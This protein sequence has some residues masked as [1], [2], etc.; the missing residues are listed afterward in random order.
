MKLY[1][2]PEILKVLPDTPLTTLCEGDEKQ[3]ITFEATVASNTPI[4]KWSWFIEGSDRNEQIVDVAGRITGSNTGVLTIKPVLRSDD[5]L[6][7]VKVENKCGPT[8]SAKSELDVELKAH[9]TTSLPALT[10]ACPGDQVVLTMEAEG[11][12]VDYT[13]EKNAGT[14]EKLQTKTLVN[15]SNADEGVYTCRVHNACG[16]DAASTTLVVTDTT[17]FQLSAGGAYCEGED[18][19][20]FTLNGS[21]DGILYKLY[22][23]Q[24]KGGDKLEQTLT[25]TGSALTFKKC[26]TPLKQ[27]ASFY[28]LAEQVDNGI[29]CIYRMD[30]EAVL[31]Q[32]PLPNKYNLTIS[33]EYCSGETFAV[34][35]LSGSEKDS[36]EYTLEQKTTTG[37]WAGIGFAQVGTGAAMT[38]TVE[39][40]GVYRVSARNKNTRCRVA[41]NYEREILV[42]PLPAPVDLVAENGNLI[43]CAGVTSDVVLSVPDPEAGC[44]YTLKKE[45]EAG[46]SI[47]SAP[48]TWQQV[49]AGEYVLIAKNQWGCE[50]QVAQQTVIE[51]P[52]PLKFTLTGGGYYCN[53]E[54]ADKVLTLSGSERGK[55]YELYSGGKLIASQPGAGDILIYKV[56]LS[57]KT[58]TVK[59]T[60]TLTGCSADMEGSAVIKANDLRI[61]FAESPIKFVYGN[62][63]QIQ[64]T[65][66]G[67]VGAREITWEPLSK[68]KDA[69]QEHVEDPVT[70]QLFAGQRFGVTVTDEGSGCTATGF[71]NAM[72]DGDVLTV[73]INAG[74]CM[75]PV[76]TIF[77]CQDEKARLCANAMGGSGDYEYNWY[78]VEGSKISSEQEFAYHIDRSGYVYLEVT[79]RGANAGVQTG[80][81]KVWVQLCEPPTETTLANSGLN[82]SYEGEQ[83]QVVVAGTQKGTTYILEHS[84]NNVNF[85]EANCPRMEGTGGQV[86]FSM[87]YEGEESGGFYRVKA[88]NTY[89][90]DGLVTTCYSVVNGYVQVRQGA[91]R[92][93]VSGDKRTCSLST[94]PDT[95]WMS[96][97]EVNVNYVLVRIS[98]S[99]DQQLDSKLG[100]GD[101]MY[102]NGKLG[103]GVYKIVAE[104][105]TCR[106]TMRGKADIR[107]NYL[108]GVGEIVD[109]GDRCAES[110][111]VLAITAAEA[112]VKYTLY[113]DSADVNAQLIEEKIGVGGYM[114]FDKF[115]DSRLGSYYI[116][117]YD[118]KCARSS[119]YGTVRVNP[120]A[121]PVTPLLPEYLCGVDNRAD[122]RVKIVGPEQG[123]T[124]ELWRRSNNKKVATN[125]EI[126]AD[127]LWLSANLV[128]NNYFLKGTLGNCTTEV[129]S[130]VNVTITNVPVVTFSI[131]GRYCE[132]DDTPLTL[133]ARA[134]GIFELRKDSADVKG[135]LLE[136][137]EGSG[138][139]TFTQYDH[140]VGHYY[141]VGKDK[142][143]HCSVVYDDQLTLSRVPKAVD[144]L[145][146]GPY[147]SDTDTALMAI[148]LFVADSTVEYS[149]YK[150]NTPVFTF[151]DRRKDTLYYQ[152]ELAAG[153][154][155]VR[156]VADGNESCARYVNEH[157]ELIVQQTPG[158]GDITEPK[159]KEY[160]AT[161]FDEEGNEPLSITIS[162]AEKGVTYRLYREVTGQEPELLSEK[163]GFNGPVRFGEAKAYSQLGNYYIIATDNAASCSK[164]FDIVK[165]VNEPQQVRLA[166]SDTLCEG[167]K[168]MVKL[169][170]NVDPLINYGIYT[171]S[172]FQLAQ[173]TEFRED[174][175]YY[176]HELPAGAYLIRAVVGGC[177]LV[178]EDTLRIGR[179]PIPR[180]GELTGNGDFC[181]HETPVDM[182]IS[183]A[184][185]DVKYTLY[186][187][188]G[189][190]KDMVMAVKENQSDALSFGEFSD[191]GHYHLTAENTK[192]S[193]SKSI[194]FATIKSSPDSVKVGG[195][196]TYCEG[197]P[198]TLYIFPVVDSV[199]YTLNTADGDFVAE[200]PRADQQGDTLY[201]TRLLNPGNYI[202]KARNPQGCECGVSKLI[203]VICNT[204]PRIN[205]FIGK[206]T[207]CENAVPEIG[208][209]DAE[210]NVTYYLY[211]DSS[212]VQELMTEVVGEGRTLMLGTYNKVGIYYLEAK[213]NEGCRATH[214]GD[215]VLEAPRML[216]VN[217]GAEFCSGSTELPRVDMKAWPVNQQGV[218]YELWSANDRKMDNLTNIAGDTLYYSAQL[219]VGEY[220]VIGKLG[221]CSRTMDDK[222]VVKT[223]EL[224]LDKGLSGELV[225]CA[226]TGLDMGILDAQQDV[227]YEL[228]RDVAEGDGFCGS[229]I[230]I[231][232]E[233]MGINHFNEPGEYYIIATD[234]LDCQRTLTERYKITESPKQFE[235]TG[236]TVYCDGDDGV[237]LGLS[238]TEVGIRYRLQKQNESGDFADVPGVYITGV[239]VVEGE[240]K[241]VTFRK[242]ITAG[243]Y[244]VKTDLDHCDEMIGGVVTITA[245]SRPQ[246]FAVTVE[247]QG[248]V[249]STLN[250]VVHNTETEVAYRLYVNDNTTPVAELPGNG[251]DQNWQITPDQAGIYKVVADR[252]GCTL[253][254]DVAVQIDSVPGL[255]NLLDIQPVCVGNT[256]D[257]VIYDYDAKASYS[258]YDSVT[259]NLVVLG[260]KAA[261]T[262]SFKKIKPGTYYY[263]AERGACYQFSPNVKVDT[264]SLPVLAADQVSIS[265]CSEE[266]KVWIR[267]SGLTSDK[268]YAVVKEG[269][270]MQPYQF[271]GFAGDTV[272]HNLPL[273]NYS[274]VVTDPTINCQGLPVQIKASE[275]VA[276]DVI[277]GN[278]VYCEDGEGVRLTLSGSTVRNKY[279]IW[280]Q[281]STQLLDTLVYPEI[282]FTGLYKKGTYLFVK[283]N[284]G[285][286]GGC[287][288]VD[289]LKVEELPKPDK[290]IQL[291][292]VGG[293]LLCEGHQYQLMVKNTEQDVTYQ[294]RRVDGGQD[295]MMDMLLGDRTDR[296]FGTMITEAGEYKVYA[297]ST[298]DC[299]VY[300]DT[301]ITI[302]KSPDQ[303]AATADPYCYAY[304]ASVTSGNSPIELDRLALKVKYK[305]FDGTNYLDSI[306]GSSAGRFK[307][308]PAGTYK[309]IGVDLKNGCTDTVAEVNIRGNMAPAIFNVSGAGEVYCGQNLDI[310]TDGSEGDTITYTL[311]RG[312][313]SMTSLSGDDGAGLSFG[314][315]TM[316]G[317]YKVYAENTETKCASWMN[318]SVVIAEQL[319]GCSPVV[320]G[321]YCEGSLDGV[322][323]KYDCS[324]SGWNYY[325][326]M[327]GNTS[328]TLAGGNGILEWTEAGGE[329]LRAGEYELRGINV[330]GE[331]QLVTTVSVHSKPLPV[332]QH[333]RGDYEQTLC[334]EDSWEAVLEGSETGVTYRLLLRNGDNGVYVEKVKAE[335]QGTGD[336]LS[337]GTYMESGHYFVEA[338]VDSSACTLMMDSVKLKQGAVLEP[339]TLQAENVCL[340]AP[341]THMTVKVTSGL[342]TGDNKYDG[343][344]YL[345]WNEVAVD[346][347]IPNAGDRRTVFADQDSV[348]IYTVHAVNEISGC[349]QIYGSWGVEEK[350]KVF[351]IREDG[352]HAICE[353][354]KQT[355]SLSGSQENV[356][357]TLVL[358]NVE[359]GE[360]VKGTGAPLVIGNVNKE[361][362]YRVFTMYG[363]NS[364]MKGS[365]TVNV[366]P[367]P[368]FKPES[369]ELHICENG[370][371]VEVK[372]KESVVG[373]TYDLWGTKLL[374]SFD[375]DGG[376]FIFTGRGGVN[377]V[378]NTAGTYRVDITDNNTGCV[379]TDSVVLVADPFPTEFALSTDGDKYLCDGESNLV[380]MEQ[381]EEG[382]SYTLMREHDGT[383]ETITSRD[384]NGGRVDFGRVNRVGD[385]YLVATRRATENSNTMCSLT[386][387]GRLSFVNPR[388]INR[389]ALVGRDSNYCY[390]EGPIAAV[391]LMGTDMGVQYELYRN[392][393]PTGKSYWGGEGSVL[394]DKLA[395]KE[396]RNRDDEAN[397]YVY[398][399]IASD[400]LTGCQAPMH[401][402]VTVIKETDI[403][404]IM[405]TSD[406]QICAGNAVSLVVD[407]YGCG[408]QYQWLHEDV[409]VK[410]KSG[411]N[412]LNIPE[413]GLN[414][415]G[416]YRCVL[417]NTCGSA[418]T[419]IELTVRDV[420]KL[421]G[422]MPDIHICGE[423]V[424]DVVLASQ[425]IAEYYKWYPLNN[426]KEILGNEQQLVLKNATKEKN[427]GRYVCYA[428]N[429]DC[430]G[431]YDTCG[432]YF[433]VKPSL[434][435]ELKKDA[436]CSGTPYSMSVESRDTVYWYFEGTEI[437]KGNT[438]ELAAAYTGH[439]GL[440]T[441][442][443]KNPCLTSDPY[444]V[445]NLIVDTTLRLTYHSDT[446]IRSCEGEEVWMELRTEPVTESMSYQWTQNGKKLANGNGNNY[447]LASLPFS[448][449][450]LVY[451]V[452]YQNACG[453]D[454]LNF[455]IKADKHITYQPLPSQI[456]LC[457]DENLK[458][459]VLRLNPDPE[460]DAEYRWYFSA[461]KEGQS[462]PQLVGTADSLRVALTSNHS[463]YYYC[464]IA[465]TCKD[466]LTAS[467][468]IRIDSVPVLK[469]KL[470]NIEV[471]AGKDVEVALE[472]SGGGLKY[473]WTLE[474]RTKETTTK[475]Y[476]STT[477]NSRSALTIPAIDMSYDS[478]RI[479]CDVY[480]DC[481][482]Q[483]VMTTD[484]MKITVLDVPSL[485]DFVAKKD[486]VCYGSRYSLTIPVK[487]G[488]QV[489]W[490]FNSQLQ[491]QTGNT[492]LV[493]AVDYSSQGRYTVKLTNKCV[494]EEV[495]YTVSDLLVDTALVVTDTTP[496]YQKICEGNS[497]ALKVKL[498]PETR[499]TY[500]WTLDGVAKGNS[501]SLS[502]GALAYRAEG[503]TYRVTY[504]NA[505][506]PVKSIDMKIDVDRQPQVEPLPESLTL[507]AGAGESTT[508]RLR[509]NEGMN[510]RFTW[511]YRPTM[512]SLSSKISSADTVAI[513]LKVENSGYYYY[514]AENECQDVAD[515]VKVTIDSVPVL[516]G[517]LRDTMVCKGSAMDLSLQVK[518]GN[519]DCRWVI[520]FAD[521]TREELSEKI[522]AYE[523]VTHFRKNTIDAKYEKSRVC[524]VVTNGCGTVYSDTM[525]IRVLSQPT[526]EGL[527][528]STATMCEGDSLGI[529]LNTLD[530][531][532]WFRNGEAIGVHE[533][534]LSVKEVALQDSGL[535]TVQVSNSCGSEPKEFEV[536]RVYI[537]SP[538]TIKDTS[539]THQHVCEGEAVRLF[540][541]TSSEERVEYT[542][543]EGETVLGHEYG[544]TLDELEGGRRERTISVVYAN[545]CQSDTLV[546]HLLIDDSLR[547]SPLSDMQLC[548]E[549]GADTLIRLNYT[550]HPAATWQ[551]FYKAT[552][553]AEAV[554]CG[555]TDSLRIVRQ[556]DHAGEYYYEARNVCGLKTDGM[557]VEIDTTP[558]VKLVLKDTAVCTGNEFTLTQEAE[559]GHLSYDW[560]ITLKD[561]TVEHQDS[562]FLLIPE[563]SKRYDSCV[564][565]NEVFNG[566]GRVSAG[567]MV[568]RMIDMPTM[569]PVELRVDTLCAGADYALKVE[570]D[571]E[572]EWFRGGVSTGVKTVNF[573]LWNISV[574]DSGMY[575]VRLANSCATEGYDYEIGRLLVD[576]EITVDSMS[577]ASQEFCEGTAPVLSIRTI[578]SERVSYRWM[579]YGELVGTADTLQLPLLSMAENR[580]VYE[581]YY[582][583]KCLPKKA[584]MSVTVVRGL[585]EDPLIGS[586]EDCA[587]DETVRVALKHTGDFTADYTWSFKPAGADEAADLKVGDDF[588]DIMKKT[589]SN[590]VYYVDITNVCGTMT[591]S[592]VVRIDS[593]APVITRNLRAEREILDGNGLLDTVE[594]SGLNLSYKWTISFKNGRRQYVRS[595]A[596]G[597]LSTSDILYD[598]IDN[599]Y[600]SCRIWCNITN[601]CGEVCTDT[602]LVRVKTV[603]KIMVSPKELTICS[604]DVNE[605]VVTLKNG[606]APWEYDYIMP[607]NERKRVRV[608]G[609]LS[610]TIRGWNIEGKYLFPWMKAT[611][612][613]GEFE[614]GDMR[615][616]V[617]LTINPVP[618]KAVISG[619]TA[620]CY[621]E[622]AYLRI[623][624][625]GGVTPWKITLRKKDGTPAD[626]LFGNAEVILYHRDTLL[627]FVVRKSETYDLGS[628]VVLD[629]YQNELCT[630]AVEGEAKIE[631]KTKPVISMKTPGK[632]SGCEQHL[633]ALLAISPK[634]GIYTFGQDTL[635]GDLFEREEGVYTG[636][637]I[638][639][640]ENGCVTVS[641]PFV[642]EV[643][644]KPSLSFEVGEKNL[645][646]GEMTTVKVIPSGVTTLNARFKVSYYRKGNDSTGRSITHTF[647]QLRPFTNTIVASDKDS[648]IIYRMEE[649]SDKY[650]CVATANVADTIFVHRKPEIEVKAR[651]DN[652]NNFDWITEKKEFIISSKDIVEV[653]VTNKEGSKP[654]QMLMTKDEEEPQ[655]L[656]ITG[657]L[658]TV[659]RINTS[660]AYKFKATNGYC[661]ASATDTVKV[662][663]T[664][665]G[666]VQ[667]KVLLAGPYDM[668]AKQMVS[669]ISAYLPLKGLKN[670]FPA[671]GGRQIIDW[672]TVELREFPYAK[673]WAKQECL[674]LSDGTVMT[675]EGSEYIGFPISTY[676]SL[677]KKSYYVILSQ[678]NHLPVMTRVAL[679]LKGK[680]AEAT[681]LDFTKGETVY[682]N[683]EGT[684]YLQDHMVIT[685]DGTC[686]MAPG[687]NNGNLLIS[688]FDQ[689]NQMLNRKNQVPDYD[690]LFWDLNFDGLIEG[691]LDNGKIGA[692]LELIRQNRDKYSPVPDNT[693]E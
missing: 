2:K 1:S 17:M 535:Y 523:G 32:N 236:E 155:R 504:S 650:K 286:W 7:Y 526:I 584:T 306:S 597:Y 194:D 417:S 505:C 175:L 444:P 150:E 133:T 605:V 114:E 182:G 487:D 107:Y 282:N 411:E 408:L 386:F 431:V 24:A 197:D 138:V 587:G 547:L 124:Y 152:G 316:A 82:C 389:Y 181:Y 676:T 414:D 205:D 383:T 199:V 410:A 560:T 51:K 388:P 102:F 426:D 472:A 329:A 26:T 421:V 146:D 567:E 373:V 644:A 601:L 339:L 168:G 11:N 550:G 385:Y 360:P 626:D 374:G 180:L 666:F 492:Y 398:T 517:D 462:E 687:E 497:V 393:E 563:V 4:T 370:E 232:G 25:G 353:G 507:C 579:K 351:D 692:D 570:T 271:S 90:R 189:E 630:A 262:V 97:S 403:D 99:G 645:C 292:A 440:Y 311:K 602:M 384:G 217:G 15:V 80:N 29:T 669:K 684:G 641:S 280:N 49:A 456:M 522:A 634:G 566:C 105:G 637:Y 305:L 615:K 649:I 117:A 592:M 588:V 494:L 321:S 301:V 455:R 319:A 322:T 14:S 20:A 21:T 412:F 670:G 656:K 297:Q 659:L 642:L 524:C 67:A 98:D 530:R 74:D 432:V 58:Y 594:A 291:E 354:E 54:T 251:A 170:G 218:T 219:P 529:T 121:K 632:I 658:D 296:A 94:L 328:D 274:V 169:F 244:R 16:D 81:A 552:A 12:N 430:G 126:S 141:V 309:I 465:N 122:V 3:P 685:E 283:Q 603:P 246:P 103:T 147:C 285:Y 499:V 277:V 378:L 442:R 154:Y 377:V 159:E 511:Y 220:R 520:L 264:V 18:G 174:T 686:L 480:S 149:L 173:F 295:V 317:I 416:Y 460:L 439:S 434:E 679:Q 52:L 405:K 381:S 40:E 362:V 229:V 540:I 337:F 562:R 312:V 228:Y 204:R 532:A 318:D 288:T 419:D 557:L 326:R 158:I 496:S 660:G 120:V 347:I 390:R 678:R 323:I 213:T 19:L 593:T 336:E 260:E 151:A 561:H 558:V 47:S 258:L 330:C 546:M 599:T 131:R 418:F 399:V 45:G 633:D 134:A 674:L 334:P 303:I 64:M 79:S 639:T 449:D 635:Q 458:D 34:L 252:N 266:N 35:K 382:V 461:N 653:A 463:G 265:D 397:G 428:W 55:K 509:Y 95:V 420:A 156:A 157:V 227:R 457:A 595:S 145:N 161:Y 166:G 367:L 688:V 267:L 211:R 238:G 433:N 137:L 478:C 91:K 210:V 516:I 190:Q 333:L 112:G 279:S 96:G 44:A 376:A 620:V 555:D 226:G 221:N 693:K 598:E 358:N 73:A 575:S 568:L 569:E 129:A 118:E 123:V 364:E 308:Q 394:W 657:A 445:A 600:D 53:T 446:M 245:D 28:V 257:L 477:Y 249:D 479:W 38:W 224:P 10:A 68:L 413:V 171:F 429:K 424:T 237:T 287:Y 525:E 9:F 198:V 407:A 142:D 240:L 681:M 191:L 255:G 629:E 395:G 668:T 401:N 5:G 70:A 65:V 573:N 101:A 459:T 239:G 574:A 402:S 578:P 596:S 273:G 466:S 471:C 307:A 677:M 345:Y 435:V 652:Y 31:R 493:R 269:T 320:E 498:Q 41:M 332:V 612:A 500:L 104:K 178:M 139:L 489:K 617:N 490:Y 483:G 672:I 545:T 646:P 209:K 662:E 438:Y 115:D 580:M 661:D 665:T 242:K 474:K 503:Y 88:M 470:E 654:W 290:T 164:R 215:T 13:W 60:D 355:V 534:I 553:E 207:Y 544:L 619:D 128:P 643:A 230:G 372:V 179:N 188:L 380:M 514:A 484:T 348:G 443:A 136:T 502:T 636:N 482:P 361:G 294:L 284:V 61:S 33:K 508:L 571:N 85:T 62:S 533:N 590:G 42:R 352:T 248:C 254:G 253:D 100:T 36:I 622:T 48:F 468:R 71:V 76:D 167:E 423:E 66:S 543:L 231:G 671:T 488:V 501:E 89:I 391:T 63:V 542:W 640:G 607:N 655:V 111:S 119:K 125:Q 92:F 467:C 160:C 259:N 235:L 589:G 6:Y 193:C 515:T 22:R 690:I 519:L 261:S 491:G 586:I 165:I 350:P 379:R 132:D 23:V 176:E 206:G 518:G 130:T 556:T 223:R 346:S 87:T 86:A 441:V 110:G 344:F 400:T 59:A 551:W 554:A 396:C 172:N 371:G 184:E 214:A 243:T 278:P 682:I 577:P 69:S 610:D 436:I 343:R 356:T 144:V 187:D 272:L 537:D 37:E 454:S 510:G 448:T 548:A 611:V 342:T 485:P 667:C 591:D 78:Q 148:K 664:D 200:F 315:Q 225:A 202:I 127:S 366:V 83:F 108:P 30:G 109:N 331:D 300:L 621:N 27:P 196:R 335:I 116:E 46:V 506:R 43:A 406:M 638:Y 276:K 425:A 680:K 422:K 392:G 234:P 57:A 368:D 581:V 627:P 177:S 572:I 140:S 464:E 233:D 521:N 8:V 268:I 469:N 375:G 195:E 582:Q 325:L 359:I 192:T 338:V 453:K 216:E 203:E 613:E 289:T 528:A 241:P 541:K 77:V 349:T 673:T 648:C 565:T 475:E 201:A 298:T 559:G 310:R 387:S 437:A 409:E 341:G 93:T 609:R 651:N 564:I 624:V 135:K 313:L 675:A 314:A 606:L 689:V 476:L 72:Q 324:V 186:R 536:M 281:D 84:T 56:P 113:R 538:L 549:A 512:E 153:T 616:H 302:S 75:T 106:D 647:S 618:I 212:G 293:P 663:V 576:E 427:E 299:G 263:K 631:V 183:M 365:V 50:Q 185:P 513:P 623:H 247:G 531:V 222:V 404:S 585:P 304:G 451:T 495:E 275:S 583:N 143:G 452:H 340:P 450:T 614:N 363:C 473:V 369:R 327:S 208:I 481:L 162:K 250:I 539:S 39:E 625:E 608:E 604:S 357:Y 163:E 415:F 486:T 256:T 628:L 683:P 447:V 691:V 270:G 527:V